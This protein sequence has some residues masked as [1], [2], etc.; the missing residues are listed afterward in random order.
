MQILLFILA[1]TSVNL[2]LSPTILADHAGNWEYT[3]QSPEGTYEGTIVLKQDGGEYACH[4]ESDGNIIETT[5]LKVEGNDISYNIVVMGYPVTIKGS[6]EGDVL[7]AV[8]SV[9]GYELPFE[10]KRK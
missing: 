6:F 10:A 2:D 4:M 5:D 9:E 3:I 7:K 8:A 1:F